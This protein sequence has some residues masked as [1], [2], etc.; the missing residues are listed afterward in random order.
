[1]FGQDLKAVYKLCRKKRIQMPLP[2]AIYIIQQVCK[3]LDYAHRKRDSKGRPQDIVHRDV[4]P[5]N[6]LIS[7]EGEVKVADFGIARAAS[8]SR[9][10]Q[11]GTLKGKIAYMSPEQA[12]GKAVDRRSDIFS[13]G[14]VFWEILSNQRLF[15]GN[16]DFDTLERVR[17]CDIPD[18]TQHVPSLSKE[19]DRILRKGLAKEV[20]QRYQSAAEMHHD[21]EVFSAAHGFYNQSPELAN[22]LRQ[23]FLQAEESEDPGSSGSHPR[24]LTA[25]GAIAETSQP[26]ETIERTDDSSKKIVGG[27]PIP[28]PLPAVAQ[29]VVAQ[30]RDATKPPRPLHEEDDTYQAPP[31]SEEFLDAAGASS[32]KT[33]TPAARSERSGA[34][35]LSGARRREGTGSASVKAETREPS[36]RVVAPKPAPPAED[37][38]ALDEPRRP[39]KRVPVQE[40]EPE[41]ALEEEAEVLEEEAEDE[42]WEE[43]WEDAEAPRSGALVAMLVVVLVLVL[44]GV[45]GVAIYVMRERGIVLPASWLPPGRVVVQTLPEAQVFLGSQLKGTADVS[46]RLTLSS[47]S[48]G[49]YE[50]KISKA[51]HADWTKRIS[52]RPKKGFPVTAYLQPMYGKLT[53]G[54]NE[55][56]A[57]IYLDGVYYTRTPLQKDAAGQYTAVLETVPP[58]EHVITLGKTDRR[59]AE[60]KVE[61]PAD[62]SASVSVQLAEAP[63][64]WVELTIEADQKNSFAIL[65]G[66]FKGLVQP[67]TPLQ[68]RLEQGMHDLIVVKS[69][70]QPVFDPAIF[71][72][73]SWSSEKLKVQ[74]QEAVA[75][76]VLNI[77]TS[78]EGYDLTVDGREILRGIRKNAILPGIPQGRHTVRITHPTL[79]SEAQDVELAVG[80]MA[81]LRF[82]LGAGSKSDVQVQLVTTPAQA[83]VFLDGKFLGVSDLRF[84]PPASGSFT[85]AISLPGYKRFTKVYSAEE[86]KDRLEIALEKE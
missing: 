79:G 85:L 31:L 81:T 54:S 25:D 72:R 4:S 38:E 73:K 40:A 18:I 75:T 33:P 83:T 78:A 74:F 55:P 7:Y 34:T 29:Q 28:A 39:A 67:E 13:I 86:I 22:F 60:A 47:V 71:R 57:R 52:V 44:G 10:T 53:V 24:V 82:N 12:W 2:L 20:D 3:G 36:K 64:Q 23:H 35:D 76:G 84:R 8:S 6:I 1:V 80:D 50:L 30:A 48:S 17:S 41:P 63:S 66:D 45:A 56:G 5:Q 51:G 11:A 69:S 43:E 19:I 26:I 61:L 42:E 16:S 46:G 21:L 68:V 14:I 9:M 59:D 58:G 37:E 32:S 77:L 70:Y 65:D 27:P 15:F 49:S 62:G